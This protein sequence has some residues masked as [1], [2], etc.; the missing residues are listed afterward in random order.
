M[1]YIRFFLTCVT[2]FC[3]CY[4]YVITI[5]IL[6]YQEYDRM[7]G[8]IWGSFAFII[9]LVIA[10]SAFC[11]KSQKM[12]LVIMLLLLIVLGTVIKFLHIYAGIALM[13]LY[14]LQISDCIC[15][16]WVQ[17]QQGYPYFNERYQE[18]EDYWFMAKGCARNS[19]QQELVVFSMPDK[20]EQNTK[21]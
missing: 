9:N 19:K 11:A 7:Y 3:N 17:N 10:V 12:K 8:L 21:S 4:F 18:Q 20:S 5:P 16:K 2:L 15:M 1:H 13:I 14:V 6:Y